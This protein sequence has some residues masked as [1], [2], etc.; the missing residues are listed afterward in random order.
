MGKRCLCPPCLALRGHSVE[1]SP[2]FLKASTFYLLGASDWQD[3]FQALSE[4]F[5]S[6]RA[7]EGTQDSQ[8][9]VFVC[10][11]EWVW[12]NTLFVKDFFKKKSLPKRHWAGILGCRRVQNSLNCSVCSSAE[13]AW[14]SIVFAKI[15]NPLNLNA[16]TET[17]PQHLITLV[18]HYTFFLH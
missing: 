10:V 15:V 7:A 11:F 2:E 5:F 4:G 14:C 9:S 17:P 6:E 8:M 16:L 18:Y 1:L 12:M 3:Y 13:L